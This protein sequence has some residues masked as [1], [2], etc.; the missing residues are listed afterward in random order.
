MN[1]MIFST[2]PKTLRV[3]A[4][5][6]EPLALK[7][8]ELYISR[9]PYLVPVA[10]C[11][12]AFEAQKHLDACDAIFIDINMPDLSG[13]DFI[14]SLD[15]PPLVVFT[16]AYADYA[17]EG[18]RVNAVDYLLKPISF[19]DFEKAAGRLR[20]RLMQQDAAG[21]AAHGKTLYFKSDYHLVTV[22]SDDILFIQG[23]GEYIKIYRRSDDL[24]LITLHG[25]A[26][27]LSELPAGDFIQI[28]R[29]YIVSRNAIEK[30]SRT[31]VILTNGQKLP[32]GST[33]KKGRL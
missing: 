26:K 31:E 27:V 9:I 8:M 22:D 13:M 15:H 32:I 29:S 19:S 12:S 21:R 4:V 28:H 33:F 24:P 7:Q 17:V 11:H 23:M 14:K 25:L 6:D 2:A 20:D 3:L 5:D 16:T 18:F 30:Y 1:A 10:A